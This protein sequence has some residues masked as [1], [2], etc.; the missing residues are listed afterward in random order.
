MLNQGC[1]TNIVRIRQMGCRRKQ[2]INFRVTV[3]SRRKYISY[4]H[5]IK[6][7]WRVSTCTVGVDLKAAW[8]S[9]GAGF[10]DAYF[11]GIW[12][13]RGINYIETFIWRLNDYVSIRL[14]GQRWSYSFFSSWC[15]QQHR[16]HK[17]HWEYFERGGK[18]F[19]SENTWEDGYRCLKL[20]KN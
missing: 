6:H 3:T 7:A 20:R 5:V 8:D 18:S 15:F 16:P 11:L 1:I 19:S 2:F 13:T 4:F 9:G 14:P 10:K 12:G 17:R